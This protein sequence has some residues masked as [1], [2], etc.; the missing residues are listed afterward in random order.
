MIEKMFKKPV[1]L[2][3]QNKDIKFSQLKNYK[4]SRNLGAIAINYLE[5]SEISKHYPIFFVKDG[6]FFTPIALLGAKS[7]TNLFV[8]KSGEWSGHRYIPALIRLYPFI[9]SKP[10]NNGDST[11]VSIAYDSEF[12]G[13]NDHN[14]ERFFKDDLSLSD[15]GSRVMKF[16]EDTFIAINRTQQMLNIAKEIGLLVQIDITFGKNGERDHK[17][18]GLW[19]IDRTK[20]NSL[21]DDEL[22]KLTKSGTLHLIYNH[23]DSANNFDNLVNKIV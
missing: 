20:L 10:D 23:I 2:T 12:D 7:D 5:I 9:F 6:E 21:T 4:H 8:N 18:N 14:G 15:F 16:A 19:Q 22:L 13:L 17:I 3:K 11:V 1:L